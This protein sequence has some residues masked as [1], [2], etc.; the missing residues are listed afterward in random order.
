MN[1][2]NCN[3]TSFT[4]K[5]AIKISTLDTRVDAWLDWIDGEM[6]KACDDQTRVWCDIPGIIPP[7]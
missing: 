4:G 6:I 1:R 3:K 7:L 5:L 2:C